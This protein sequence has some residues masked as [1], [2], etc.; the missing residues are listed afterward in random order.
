MICWFYISITS[1]FPLFFFSQITSFLSF[2]FVLCIFL[3]A[4]ISGQGSNK[5]KIGVDFLENGSK[6]KNKSPEKCVQ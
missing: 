4:L 2:P 6:Y 5:K 1:D 3:P